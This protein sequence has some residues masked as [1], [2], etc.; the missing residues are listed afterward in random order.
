VGA[1]VP[2]EHA[3]V[4]EWY[5]KYDARDLDALCRLADSKIVVAPLLTRLPGTTFHG[6]TGL[7]TLMQWA[8]DTYPNSR[9]ESNSLRGESGMVLAATRFRR[10]DPPGSVVWTETWTL[11][12]GTGDKV[13]RVYVF[14]NETDA[15]TA[16]AR[17]RALTPRERQVFQRVAQGLTVQQIADELFLSPAT[18]RTHVR[19]GI[20]H[21]GA[22]NKANAISLAL[23]HREI[24]A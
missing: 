2:I 11:F 4:Q 3:T 21:L 13:R 22:S 15:L 20:A 7:R 9:V 17:K 6:H 12:D 10:E 23:K 18:V 14:A 1:A 8:F 16:A 19:N 24:T 5:A